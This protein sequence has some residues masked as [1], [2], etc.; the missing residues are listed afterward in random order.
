MVHTATLATVV[1]QGLLLTWAL[2]GG[3]PVAWTLWAVFVAVAAAGF[4]VESLAE[5]RR[6]RLADGDG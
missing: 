3:S 5:R 6:R 2:H 4:V 1:A